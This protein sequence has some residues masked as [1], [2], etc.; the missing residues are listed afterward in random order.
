MVSLDKPVCPQHV[1][2]E[3][4][5]HYSDDQ[6]SDVWASAVRA[7]NEERRC[8]MRLDN[9]LLPGDGLCLQW[10][11][12]E[13]ER[14]LAFFVAQEPDLSRKI[15]DQGQPR[16]PDAQEFLMKMYAVDQTIVVELRSFLERI[17]HRVHQFLS[18][19]ETELVRGQTYSSAFERNRVYVE[20]SLI[21]CN[22]AALG[23]L[24]SAMKRSADADEASRSQ[25]L[26]A[27]RRVLK[28]VADLLYPASNET[29][30]GPDGK[31]REMTEPKYINRLWQFLL[32]S[33]QEATL[34]AALRSA[35]SDLG[36]RL[37][38]LHD[39][40]NKGVHAT[41]S[42]HEAD[43]CVSMTYQL[44]GDLLRTS[45]SSSAKSAGSASVVGLHDQGPKI[46][47][48]LTS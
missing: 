8:R 1:F 9:P 34:G 16:S 40:M 38:S 47:S 7:Y 21:K 30:K 14:K 19:T 25:A 29:I 46:D 23:E 20:T 12:P 44:V 3:L 17:A 4:R 45:E 11:I 32:D 33:T 31:V 37:D 41:V 2:E 35:L 5:P 13:I 36:G 24:Q 48:Q 42:A 6:W 22:P 10:S 28:G 27:C 18:S 39:L 26:L 43:T 15:L